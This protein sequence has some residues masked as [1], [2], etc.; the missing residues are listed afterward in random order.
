MRAG[1][2][3]IPRFVEEML[4][5]EPPVHGVFRMTTQEVELGGV[6]LPKGARIP[7]W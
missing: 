6:R 1:R 7:H 3:L 4:R 2:S 5:H